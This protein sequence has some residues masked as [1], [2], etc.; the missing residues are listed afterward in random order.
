MEVR[1]KS[2]AILLLGLALVKQGDLKEVLDVSSEGLELCEKYQLRHTLWQI[3][4]LRAHIADS[5][6]D[7]E[8]AVKYS[9][10]VRLLRQEIATAIAIPEHLANFKMNDTLITL[11]L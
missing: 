1:N 3:G 7:K 11:R 8:L 9:E 5:L 10:S 4:A 2:Q 6:G